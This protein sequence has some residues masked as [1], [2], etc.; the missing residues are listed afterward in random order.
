MTTKPKARKFRIKRSPSAATEG[1]I[2][3]IPAIAM[4][5]CEWEPKDWEGAQ[6]VSRRVAERTLREGLPPGLLLNVNVPGGPASSLKGARI[7]RQAHSRWEEQF[8]ERHDPVGRP[9]FWLG[10]RFVD[11]DDGDDTDTGAIA[12]GYVSIT[13]LHADMTAHGQINHFASW[14]ESLAPDSLLDG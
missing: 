1:A 6:G 7:T 4:S 3:G 10:G 9:Y 2:L 5:H 14:T 11:L 13:P 8:E 12:D